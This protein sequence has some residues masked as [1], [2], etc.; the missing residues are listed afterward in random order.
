MNLLT[1]RMLLFILRGALL[2]LLRNLLLL[3]LEALDLLLVLVNNLAQI[4]GFGACILDLLMRVLL[5]DQIGCLEPSV[6]I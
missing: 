2:K 5:L 6:C 1:L 3:L 4:F